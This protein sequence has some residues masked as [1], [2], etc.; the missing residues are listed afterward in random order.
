MNRPA[1]IPAATYSRYSSDNQRETSIEDQQR[2]QAQRAAVE[3][4]AIVAGFSDAEISAATPMALRPGGKAMI[5]A[6]AQSAGEADARLRCGRMLRG[7]RKRSNGAD[8]VQ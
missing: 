5:E 2:L 7:R 6:A 4:I 8:A 3:G 1:A